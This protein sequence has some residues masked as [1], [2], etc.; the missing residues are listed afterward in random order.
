[1]L[2]VDIAQA[3]DPSSGVTPVHFLHEA[4]PLSSTQYVA[5]STEKGDII[6]TSKNISRYIYLSLLVGVFINPKLFV[7]RYILHVCST[8]NISRVVCR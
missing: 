8:T 7:D 1:M 3:D 4:E 5:A 2:A 6:R